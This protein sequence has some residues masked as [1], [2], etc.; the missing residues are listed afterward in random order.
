MAFQL[1]VV[2][3]QAASVA[4]RKAT[5]S[6]IAKISS[7]IK[8]APTTD[9]IIAA[10]KANPVTAT[11]V[12]LELFGAASD[13]FKYITDQEPE[14]EKL[15]Q[16]ATPAAVSFQQDKDSDSSRKD[17][18]EQLR[19]YRNELELIA[20][21]SAVLGSRERL[22]VVRN[23]VKLDDFYFDLRDDLATLPRK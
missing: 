23:A 20:S 13:F 22:L 2:A 3:V 12:G 11:L 14:M 16:R 21:A 5:P 6:A 17:F 19:K 10:I 1:P 8:S 4:L 18:L 7:I 15:L 9:A